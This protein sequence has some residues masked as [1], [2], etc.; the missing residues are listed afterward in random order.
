M[1]ASKE[2]IFTPELIKIIK[3]FGVA[4]LA[5][6][7]V[8]SFFNEKRANNSGKEPSELTVSDSNRQFFKN[9]RT[10]WYDAENRHDARMDVYRYSKRVKEADHPLLNLAIII[11]RKEREAYIYVEPS[12]EIPFTLHWVNEENGEK[13]ILEFEGGDKFSHWEFVKRFYPLL[14]SST[15]FYLEE[16]GRKTLLFFNDKEK[17][18]LLTTCEDFWRLIGE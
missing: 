6:V 12:F 8:L 10:A 11:N 4:S 1:A 9:L 13:G 7:L 16:E 2:Q 15:E 5:L 18:A 14:T 17:Q 3:I